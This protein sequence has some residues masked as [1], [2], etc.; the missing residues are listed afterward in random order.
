MRLGARVVDRLSWGVSRQIATVSMVL[1]LMIGL[2]ACGSLPDDPASAEL[3]DPLESSNRRVYTMNKWLRQAL[4]PVQGTVAD[5]SAG[6]PVWGGV[7]NVLVN[8][9]EPLTFANDLAQG[10]ECAAG[11]SLRRFMVNSTLGV[12]GLFDV[13][14]EN[15]IAAHDNDLGLTL[16]VWGVPAGP[17][18][19]LPV[20]GPSDLRDTTGIAVEYVV[21]PVD[22]G[23]TRAG[24]SAA[25]WP[26]AALDNLDRALDTAPELD[27][28]ERSSLD[29]YAALRSA[30]RQ[31]QFKAMNDQNCPEVMQVYYRANQA[32]Q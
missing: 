6:A 29:G 10:K 23:L 8:L 25:V 3:N 13:A 30:Y 12:G 7:H 14:K 24:A 22:I 9:R 28:L 19:M 18:L 31:N 2:P 1:A 27:K 17:Y 11:A 15:G 16:G 20:L 4:G 32:T 5:G 21:D 26:R